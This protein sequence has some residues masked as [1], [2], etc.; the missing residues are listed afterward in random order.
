MIH[1]RH[2]G[3]G[4]TRVRSRTG[5]KE[6]RWCLAVCKMSECE[7]CF[8]VLSLSP[9]RKKQEKRHIRLT[10]KCQGTDSKKNQF[11]KDFATQYTDRT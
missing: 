2:A 3:P 1:K 10:L 7:F 8:C 9:E 5:K 6:R 4:G 11:A